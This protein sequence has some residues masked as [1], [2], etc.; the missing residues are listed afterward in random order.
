MPRENQDIVIGNIVAP[1][2][3][4][5]E[6]KVVVLTEFPER[7]DKG[8]EVTLRTSNGER[9]T[10]KIDQSRPGKSG[11][12]I[13][14]QGVDDRNGSEALRGADIVIDQSDLGELP[15]GSFYVFDLI[16]LKVMTE[17]G[18]EIGEVTEI[19]QGGANDVYATSTGVMIPALKDVVSKIDIEGGVMVVRPVP[20]LL[21]DDQD[22]D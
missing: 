2:G 19:L 3:V 16:G 8:H 1:F 18:R 9:R 14:F 5:G 21:P 7:F 11:V 4:R 6:V 15:E 20:G 13:K 22:A 12:T 10:M 17:D